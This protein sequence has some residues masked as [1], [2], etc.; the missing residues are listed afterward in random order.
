[1]V[2][3]GRRNAEIPEFSKSAALIDSTCIE[4]N[5][6]LQLLACFPKHGLTLKLFLQMMNYV[7][8]KLAS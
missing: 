7:T 8:E 3:F 1:M 2:F 6:F 5:S 4:I